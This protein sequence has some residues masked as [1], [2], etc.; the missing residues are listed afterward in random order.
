M[1]LQ[2]QKRFDWLVQ[3]LV[4]VGSV[5]VVIGA[6][7]LRTVEGRPHRILFDTDVDTDD[8]FGLLY[9]LKLNRSE[10]E[11]EVSSS[12]N[13]HDHQLFVFIHAPNFFGQKV[14]KAISWVCQS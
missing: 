3:M 6:S 1:L 7:N 5:L 13:I 2:K 10:F 11:L 14:L 12:S 9:I 4:V 8:L